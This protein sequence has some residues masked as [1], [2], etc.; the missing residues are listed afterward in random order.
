AVVEQVP[1]HDRAGVPAD[2]RGPPVHEQ[3]VAD[4]PD[5]DVVQVQ[6][7]HAAGP[8]PGGHAE[9][10]GAGLPDLVIVDQDRGALRDLEGVDVPRGRGEQAVLRAALLGGHHQVKGPGCGAG[11]LALEDGL[12]LGAL[13]RAPGVVEQVAGVDAGLLRVVHHDQGG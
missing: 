5:G 2:D 11:D 13:A 3:L 4:Y 1:V 12:D 9:A 8:H 7:G 6:A 10:P